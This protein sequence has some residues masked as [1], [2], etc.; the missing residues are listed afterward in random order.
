VSAKLPQDVVGPEV[1]QTW[2]AMLTGLF[3]TGAPIA[4]HPWWRR[5]FNMQLVW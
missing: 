2:V 1:Y 3:L 5:C 4:W